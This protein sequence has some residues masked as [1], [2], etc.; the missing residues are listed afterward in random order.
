MLAK[1]TVNLLTSGSL[2]KMES[3]RDING[4]TP[5]YDTSCFSYECVSTFNCFEMENR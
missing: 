1:Y 4:V 5:Y 2:S 3:V